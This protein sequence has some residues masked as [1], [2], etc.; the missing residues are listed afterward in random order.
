MTGAKD[1]VLYTTGESAAGKGYSV[2]PDAVCM[3]ALEALAQMADSIGETQSATLWRDR[4]AKMRA[5]I[6]AR[7]VIADPKYGRVWMLESAGWPNQSTVLGPLIFLAD[8][9]G[10]A[11]QDDESPK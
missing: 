5:A 4:A 2:Y 9:R 3:T 1:G 8:S 7:Y 6:P 10:F 11:P